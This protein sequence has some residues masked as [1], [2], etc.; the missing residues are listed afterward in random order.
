[1]DTQKHQF[2]G[3]AQKVDGGG[4]HGS[5]GQIIWVS[6]SFSTFLLKIHKLHQVIKVL[7]SFIIKKPINFLNSFIK[8]QFTYHKVHPFKMYNSMILVYFQSFATIT[9]NFRSFSLSQKKP[10]RRHSPSSCPTRSRLIF[11]FYRF[12]FPGHFIQRDSYS[13]WFFVTVFFHLA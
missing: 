3:N 11:F 7:R 1:M 6:T 5:M 10:I 4:E 9:T 12:A 2:H 13:M 8:I